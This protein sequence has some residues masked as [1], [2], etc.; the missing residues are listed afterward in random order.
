MSTI[1]VVVGLVIAAI[2]LLGLVSPRRLI[3]LVKSALT[4]TGLYSAAGIRVLLGVA[5]WFAA[6]TSRAPDALRILG[7]LA[8]AAGL[9]TP[10]VG[11]ERSRKLL[12]WWGSRGGGFTR[13]WSCFA[14]AFGLL[15]IYSVTP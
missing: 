8:V 9:L 14:F 5:L 4:P 15:L 3:R 1:V 11:L 2:G 7:A 10:F 13:V 6:P 12:E